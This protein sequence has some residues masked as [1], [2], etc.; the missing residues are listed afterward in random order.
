MSKLLCLLHIQNWLTYLE[1]RRSVGNGNACSLFSAFVRE[2]PSV[3][4]SLLLP[5]LHVINLSSVHIKSGG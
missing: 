4:P 3:A 5:L 2:F 1:N